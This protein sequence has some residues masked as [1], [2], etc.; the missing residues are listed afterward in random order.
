MKVRHITI[1]CLTSMLLLQA[2]RAQETVNAIAAPKI[3]LPPEEV[4]AT[5]TRF[6]YIVYGDSR[7]RRDGEALQYEHSLVV[8]GMLAA[9]KRLENSDY[10]V[11]FVM[12]SGDAVVNGGD[13]RQWNVSF[14]SLINRLTTEGGVPYF[15]A[16]GNHD[17]TSAQN[18]NSRQRQQGLRNFLDAMAQLIPPDDAPR[19]LKG[20]PTYAFGY[21]NTFVVAL[22]SNI[23]GDATQYDWV[24]AQ[25]DGLDRGRY[26]N[27]VAM[28]HH[29]VFS[30][31][32]HGGATIEPPTAVLR[33]RYM[34]LFRTHHV[35]LLLAGHDHLFE[36]WVERYMDDSGRHR[37]D[38]VVTAGGGAPLYAYEGEPDLTQYLRANQA[39]R[40]QLE[41]LVKPGKA[42]ENPYHFVIV[43]VDGDRIN[44]EVVG[45]DWGSGFRPYRSNT[46]DLRDPS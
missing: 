25:L 27:V 31:G 10:P 24:K 19:R 14:V 16:P 45:V 17:V 29:P 40:V 46:V 43:R 13:P 3:P 21:G 20:Y 30:S 33:S 35:K 11:R 26:V 42:G 12:Q 6:S 44:L 23:A 5:V 2:A 37:M 22:D 9:I 28:F 32:P 18:L 39:T 8:D 4:S 15:L 7:G 1:L 36:H 38:L 34:P 41:H